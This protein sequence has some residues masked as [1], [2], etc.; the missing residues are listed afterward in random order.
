MLKNLPEANKKCQAF[1]NRC[2][3][4]KVRSHFQEQS[5]LK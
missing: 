5:V 2:Q 3:L 1:L 4:K